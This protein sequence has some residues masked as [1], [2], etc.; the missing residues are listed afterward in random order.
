MSDLTPI[1][2]Q[3]PVHTVEEVV[4]LMTA[5]DQVLP[6]TDGIACF[7][8]LY[9]EVTKNVLANIGQATFS[10]PVFLARL[11]VIFA[12]LYFAALRTFDAGAPSTPRAWKP[13]FEA[14]ATPTIAPLPFALAGMNAHINRDLP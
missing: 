1:L 7:N 9:L 5:I 8:Q 14:R 2:G 10:D 3:T 4:A 13:L 6:P 12:N 11:D